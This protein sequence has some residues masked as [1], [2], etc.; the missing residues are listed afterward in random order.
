MVARLCLTLFFPLF[1]FPFLLLPFSVDKW[2]CLSHLRGLPL[3]WT[4]HSIV[5]DDISPLNKSW[6]E[7]KRRIGI[8]D[9]TR[10]K[11]RRTSLAESFSSLVSRSQ[12]SHTASTDEQHDL[13]SS[14]GLDHFINQSLEENQ[15]LARNVR[16]IV[17]TSPVDTVAPWIA[18][19]RGNASGIDGSSSDS[20]RYTYKPPIRKVAPLMTHGLLP[21]NG[22]LP[23]LESSHHQYTPLSKSSSNWL[24]SS[25]LP[26]PPLP[27]SGHSDT[28]GCADLPPPPPPS[29]SPNHRYRIQLLRSKRNV[30]TPIYHEQ[31]LPQLETTSSLS[32]APTPISKSVSTASSY[33][34]VADEFENMSPRRGDV[35]PTSSASS[36]K[37]VRRLL[38]PK[39][40]GEGYN[41]ISMS[42]R[43]SSSAGAAK[44]SFIIFS[45]NRES[46][47]SNGTTQAALQ[48]KYLQM[49]NNAND[50]NL[51]VPTSASNYSTNQSQGSAAILSSPEGTRDVEE[52]IRNSVWNS[53]GKHQR[54][55]LQQPLSA[56]EGS[57]LSF[58]DLIASPPKTAHFAKSS[59]SRRPGL[60][61]IPD[62][63]TTTTDTTNNTDKTHN[64]RSSSF[65]GF[66]RP[67]K[68]DLRQETMNKPSWFKLNRDREKKKQVEEE[69]ELKIA[70]AERE[71]ED[72]SDSQEEE[73]DM[74]DDMKG[75][76]AEIPLGIETTLSPVSMSPAPI[77][78][79]QIRQENANTPT[80]AYTDGMEEVNSIFDHGEWPSSSDVLPTDDLKNN[81]VPRQRTLSSPG[82]LGSPPAPP[83]PSH[84]PSASDA[85]L[86]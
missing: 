38:R 24:N 44:N 2:F 14:A 35:A 42:T 40:A 37:S 64:R 66:F 34:T 18:R 30:Q 11:G 80:S 78:P 53:I 71:I 27:K 45:A 86:Q 77:S 56:R 22:T 60:N 75:Y 32:Q 48:R 68:E 13:N 29:H 70:E 51:T 6:E 85:G 8:L 62:N 65:E 46:I 1:T 72:D 20:K 16:G 21:N 28:I 3:L 7:E 79:H 25:P 47:S 5:Q 73:D 69:N 76:S 4:Y 15:A 67:R 43:A 17:S 19:E 49:M 59:I 61:P 39:S 81:F 57:S 36:R 33:P 54:N 82:L 74:E 50:S 26:P 31:P 12:A 9:A 10:K 55:P 52:S 84:S 41:R 58:R 63:T 83:P 23:A